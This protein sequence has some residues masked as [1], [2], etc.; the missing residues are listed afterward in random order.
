MSKSFGS[1][2]ES[3]PLLD[4][5][6]N[7]NEVI[8][9]KSMANGILLLTIVTIIAFIVTRGT[10]GDPSPLSPVP[11]SNN[12]FTVSTDA[13]SSSPMIPSISSI[14]AKIIDKKEMTA[15]NAD[16]YIVNKR[17]FND[18][19]SFKQY[20]DTIEHK[21]DEG[22][23]MHI[24]SIVDWIKS[25]NSNLSITSFLTEWQYVLTFNADSS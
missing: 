10:S 13:L 12:I 25:T 7:K 9:C 3:S 14:A 22:I 15:E 4:R 6:K 20:S 21:S 11:P 19:P 5:K 18:H 8:N 24:Q 2:R 1:I 16:N 17:H 23:A